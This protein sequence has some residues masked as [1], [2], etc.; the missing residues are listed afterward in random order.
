MKFGILAAGKIAHKMAAAVSGIPE[1]EKYAV[2]SRDP[3]KAGISK[4][5]RLLRGDAGR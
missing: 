4:G 2:A 5:L 1:V 3:E